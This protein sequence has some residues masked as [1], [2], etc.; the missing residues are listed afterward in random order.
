MAK[1]GA[2]D[3]KEFKELDQKLE[4]FEKTEKDKFL[5][6]CCKELAARLLGKV[7]KRTPVGDYSKHAEEYQVQG[8]ELRRG[9]T[10]GKDSDPTT[11]ARSLPIKKAGSEY[12]VIIENIKN[13]ASYVEFGHR[14]A[15][16]RYV[17]A[18]GK[19]LKKSW[20]DG[21]F[22]LTVSEEELRRISKPVLEKKL[23]RE[24]RRV[25]GD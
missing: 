5:E 2:I 20:V 15:P 25:F 18:I 16:G 1:W 22:M 9:W 23:E 13:Y 6:D 12:I 4:K 3:Y 19:S 8:G 24:L 7:I 10:A 21:K 14:Q 17:P 11:F